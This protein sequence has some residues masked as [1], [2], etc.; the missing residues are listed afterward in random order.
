MEKQYEK[1]ENQFIV[2]RIEKLFPDNNF[3]FYQMRSD[4][5]EM[6]QEW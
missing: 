6:K 2:D 5:E 4:P 1:F 3:Y